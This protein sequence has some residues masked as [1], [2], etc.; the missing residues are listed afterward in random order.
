MNSVVTDTPEATV[1]LGRQFGGLVQGGEVFALNGDVG[2]GKTT[3]TKGLALGMGISEVVQSPTFTIERRYEVG[4]RQLAH[5]DFYRL[6]QP[7]LMRDELF[8]TLQATD[9]V[10]AVE[11]NQQIQEILPADRT[12]VCQLRSLADGRHQL[13]FTI[14]H[15]LAYLHSALGLAS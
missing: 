1:A 11:W 14:P 4:D 5:Y 3:F 12:V 8:E 6:N 13:S 2:S 10:T 15:K 9:T 7:G